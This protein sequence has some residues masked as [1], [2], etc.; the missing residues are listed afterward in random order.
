MDVN[1]SMIVTIELVLLCYRTKNLLKYIEIKERNDWRKMQKLFKQKR[2]MIVCLHER[3]LNVLNS[4]DAQPTNMF[5]VKSV[6]C[7]EID[8]QSR[9]RLA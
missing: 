8:H 1:K 2:G 7:K 3:L 5:S 4:D 6:R 9:P